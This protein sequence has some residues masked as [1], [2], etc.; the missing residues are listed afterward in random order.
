MVIMIVLVT[1]NI[2]TPKNNVESPI[3]ITTV[4]LYSV[5]NDTDMFV[6]IEYIYNFTGEERITE[7]KLHLSLDDDTFILAID[8][9][10]DPNLM[11]ATGSSGF[12]FANSAGDPLPFDVQKGQT[13]YGYIEVISTERTYKTPTFAELIPVT[14]MRSIL[15]KIP[16]PI[17]I[18]GGISLSLLPVAIIAYLIV[19]KKNTTN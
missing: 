11:N 2:H 6:D 16:G 4:N 17:F 5:H 3:T 8:R 9:L 13:L 7:E 12:F 1:G 14:V 18:I 10:Y 15:F 19:R